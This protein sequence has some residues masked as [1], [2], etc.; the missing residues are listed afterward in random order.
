MAT[1][2]TTAPRVDSGPGLRSLR[3][4]LGQIAPKLGDVAANLDMHLD[5]LEAARSQSAELV[6]FPE[7]SLVGYQLRDLVP[8]VAQTRRTPQ[9]TRLVQASHGL[10]LGFGF[11][12][13]AA[14]HRFFNSYAFCEDGRL[15][16]VHRK[17]YLPTYGLFEEGRLYA[18]GEHIRAF[19]TKLGR[20]GIVICEDLW[21]PSAMY[22]L[23]QDGAEL[24]VAAAASPLRGAD[25]GEEH[26][27][28]DVWA[29]ALK[30]YSQLFGCFVVLVNRVGFEDGLSFWGGSRV[31]APGGRSSF[32]APLLEPGLFTC[33]I[34]WNEVRRY[35]V[36]DP[37]LRSERL[38]LT[39]SELK[40]IQRDRIV[41]GPEADAGDARKPGVERRGGRP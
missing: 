39:L 13:E 14:D 23:S 11:V 37:T 7:L 41:R 1:K 26:S 27:N 33:E 36:S 6:L 38:D 25:V 4:G 32:E 18:A 22:I 16:S 20:F 29:T 19:D 10:S 34:D 24:V 30:M 31:L 28:I 17:A 3:L 5:M 40:R 35:R 21:H 12:E 15:V 2:T 9:F 8:D